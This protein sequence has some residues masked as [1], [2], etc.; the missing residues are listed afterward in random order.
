MSSLF[1]ALLHARRSTRLGGGDNFSDTEG[2]VTLQ[3]RKS[4]PD[5]EY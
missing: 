1:S 4:L 5:A 3:L 2:G